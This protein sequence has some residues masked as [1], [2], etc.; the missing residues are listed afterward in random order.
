MSQIHHMGCHEK[1]SNFE[2]SRFFEIFGVPKTGSPRPRMGI[3]D[4][5]GGMTDLQKQYV[6]NIDGYIIATFL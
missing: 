5:E 3:T 2:K 4:L 6:W 1:F